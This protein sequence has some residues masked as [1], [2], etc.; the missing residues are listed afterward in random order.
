MANTHAPY[1]TAYYGS[2]PNKKDNSAL[3]KS[4]PT[5]YKLIRDK[6][7]TLTVLHPNLEIFKD[8]NNN[9]VQ[10]KVQLGNGF[11]FV[12]MAYLDPIK[13]DPNKPPDKE[14]T[15]LTK[16]GGTPPIYY[17]YK[18]STD[19]ISY[20]DKKGPLF[21]EMELNEEPEVSSILT[22]EGSFIGD[23]Y[24]LPQK[25]IA[26]NGGKRTGRRKSSRRRK[27][28]KNKKK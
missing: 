8:E 19:D 23:P 13:E 5:R 16:M 15:V 22:H 9:P 2:L 12:R 4:S 26:L 1:P 11:I 20:I 25:T 18:M 14:W 27:S 17:S 6:E 3:V 21:K 7:L 28:R 24:Y 10:K